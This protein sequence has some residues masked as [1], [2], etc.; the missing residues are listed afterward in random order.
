[1]AWVKSVETQ[2]GYGRIQSTQLIAKAKI[3][4]VEGDEKVV[5]LDII[6]PDA[7][8]ITAY[9]GPTLQF[10]RESAAQLYKILKDTYRFGK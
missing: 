1:M 9:P 10:G 8:E 2:S 4:T 5:Q 6:G 7:T 3:F